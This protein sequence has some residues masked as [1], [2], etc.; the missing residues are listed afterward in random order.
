LS[1]APADILESDRQRHESSVSD[2]SATAHTAPPSTAAAASPSGFSFEQ[3]EPSP[4]LPRDAHQQILARA[5]S[6]GERIL[7]RARAKGY[8]EGHERGLQDGR[9][10]TAAAA[11]ALGE[12]LR[13]L[14]AVREQTADQVERDAVELALAL[15]AK[16]LAGALE[17]EPERVLDVVRGALRRVTERRRIT[18]LVDPADLDLVSGALAE[19]QIQ[20]GGIELCDVQ[21]DRRV[22]RGG[23][24]VRT[25]EG[26]IDATVATQLECARELLLADPPHGEPE[27]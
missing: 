21:A 16:I 8:D 22:G 15:S 26:E 11:Q 1:S 18:V 24:V 14:S 23:A 12:A 13:E 3:L 6:E 17:L 9:T 20:A 4:P 19:L 25:A 2:T 5:A 27:V 10:E 7:E